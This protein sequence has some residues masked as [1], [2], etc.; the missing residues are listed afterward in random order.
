MGGASG[1]PEEAGTD[2]GIAL[3]T[4]DDIFSDFDIRG[5]DERAISRDF[6]DELRLRLRRRTGESPVAIVFFIPI[7]ER[8]PQQE[9]L[10]LERLASFFRERQA[11]YR[12][13]NRSTLLSSLLLVAIGLGLA[14]GANL[15][16]DRP[17]VPS[18]LSDFLLI[19]AWFFVWNGLELLIKN[20]GEIS[21][22]SDYY[23]LLCGARLEFRD[24]EGFLAE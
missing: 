14:L 11:Y 1:P 16:V 3:D 5:Y 8:R 10:I 13:E 2:I 21:R 4:Y 12:R 9:G 6:L 24:R 20:R 7:A 18:L 23:R 19:P 22:K 17:G 15:L